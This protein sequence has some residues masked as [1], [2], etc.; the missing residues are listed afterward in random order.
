[1]TEQ[2][3][4]NGKRLLVAEDEALVAMDYAAMLAAAGAEIVATARTIAEVVGYLEDHRVDAA[5]L[6]FV[7]ADGN[8]SALQTLLA[9]KRIPFVVISG[10]PSILVRESDEQRVLHKPVSSDDLCAAVLAVCERNA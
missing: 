8:S 4:L 3:P 2:R 10:Y 1:M 6:D 7:L 5:V 9:E